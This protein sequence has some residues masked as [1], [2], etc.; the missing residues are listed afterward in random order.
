[1]KTRPRVR[2][3]GAFTLVELLVVIAIVG[4]LAAMLL[5]VLARAR[6][7]AL[8]HQTQLEMIAIATAI[9]KYESDYNRLPCSSEAMTAATFSGE[10]FTYGTI[11][12]GQQIKTPSG[13][14]DIKSPDASS[15]GSTY[16]TN[17]CEVMA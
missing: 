7:Q 13:P 11:G 4:I 10:D 3:L 16:Q 6:R 5:P 8:I 2:H 15:G 9:Q 14:V 17:N 12:T 1:M